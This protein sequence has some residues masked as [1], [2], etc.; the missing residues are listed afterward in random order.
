MEI[1]DTVGVWGGSQGHRVA[2]HAVTN[3]PLQ[4]LWGTHAAPQ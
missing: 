4:K 3:T 1:L 2:P